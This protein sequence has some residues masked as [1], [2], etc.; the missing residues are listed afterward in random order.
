MKIIRRLLLVTVVV[1]CITSSCSSSNE[2]D[3]PNIVWITSEDNS[4]HYMDLYNEHGVATPNIAALAEEG[5]LFTNA[6][7]NAPVCSAA[8]STLISGCYGPRIGSNFHRKMKIVPM[9]EGVEMY[10]AYLRKAGYYTTNNSKEDYNLI[11]ADDVWDE[12]SKKAHW[13]NRADDQPFF[14]VFNIG[15]THESRLHF[16]EE[17]MKNTPTTTKLDHSATF[18]VHPD[19]ELFAYTNAY[20]RDKIVQMDMEVGEVVKE[21]EDEGLLE[22]TIIF[23]YGDHGGV[24]P[25]SKGYVYESGLHVPLVVYIPEKYRKLA[26][27]KKGSTADEFVSF[28]DFGPT[29]LKLAGAE[30]PE[31]IDG[32]PF[33]GVKAKDR[34]ENDV[35]FGYADRFDEK[36]DMVRS[37]RVGNYKYIRSYQPFNFDGLMNNYRYKQLAYQEWY[38]LFQKGEL[39]D[40]QSQFFRTR[41]A[42]MLF[43]LESDPNETNDISELIVSKEVLDTMR[44]KLNNWVKG[45]PDLSFYPENYLIQNAF[46]NP[47]EFGKEHKADIEKYINISNLALSGFSDVE[48]QLLKILAEKDPWERYWGLIVCSTFKKESFDLIWMARTIA[49]Q[50][51]E[52]LNRVRAAEYLGLIQEVNPEK[53]MTQ[54]LYECNDGPEALLILNSIVL[55]KD[56]EFH[57]SFDIEEEKLNAEVLGNSEVQR[58]LLYI[59]GEL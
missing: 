33:M 55:M 50:D 51:D 52:L 2:T 45:M 32:T 35:T 59:S 23:Y 42:E 28:I 27:Y 13:K 30:I 43:D 22:S 17:Q 20:Y 38:G 34:I 10:P 39:N 18:P 7:S 1:A 37:V 40:V 31:G 5:V 46:Y 19:T 53:V 57:Y 9:P 12:S 11:K 26:G 14:H 25:G 48:G 4:V 8:R 24:L 54:A 56:C 36:Y 49:V 15:T 47:V 58:R 41:K 6:F 16:S 21:L 3:R 29:V 44:E